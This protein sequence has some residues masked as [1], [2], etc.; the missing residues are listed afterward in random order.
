MNKSLSYALIVFLS[1]LAASALAGPYVGLTIASDNDVGHC[2]T[3]GRCETARAFVGYDKAWGNGIYTDV[4]ASYEDRIDGRSTHDPS[5][6]SATI[7]KR[8]D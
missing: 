4:Y 2:D 8:F 3:T 1:L 5:R 7:M 6:V